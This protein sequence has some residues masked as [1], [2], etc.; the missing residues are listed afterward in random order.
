M[1]KFDLRNILDENAFNWVGVIFL[2]LFANL[3]IT[4][5][6]N[7]GEFYYSDWL[8]LSSSI[9]FLLSGVKYLR[10]SAHY[11]E[12]CEFWD[13]NKEIEHFKKKGRSKTISENLSKKMN[14]QWMLTLFPFL[15]FSLLIGI[16]F[17][18]V[19]GIKVPLLSDNSDTLVI[20]QEFTDPH[21]E[22]SLTTYDQF[23]SEQELYQ[24]QADFI[25]SIVNIYKIDSSLVVDALCCYGKTAN[26]I[27]NHRDI[28]SNTIECCYQLE[29]SK[30]N[31]I[32]NGL[33]ED[34]IKQCHWGLLENVYQRNSVGMVYLLNNSVPELTNPKM[35]SD[36]YKSFFNT[37][38]QNGVLVLDYENLNKEYEPLA[39]DAVRGIKRIR[40]FDPKE[41]DTYYYVT[42]KY[43]DA[44]QEPIIDSVLVSRKHSKVLCDSTKHIE[45][46][47]NAGFSNVKIYNSDSSYP[48]EFIVAQKM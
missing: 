23:A 10:S 48:F 14:R 40:A 32:R 7:V 33:N 41:K 16:P 27:A 4:F 46:L 30:L 12:A 39:T 6:T 8:I 31:S 34:I 5:F 21:T 24:V 13:E 43:F 35:I 45:L 26:L 2:S 20:D 17:V 47:K 38:K 37:L 3:F 28:G 19:G 29:D 1:K 44:S 11:K 18:D 36:V 25:D 22:L 9:M 42:Y 15:S